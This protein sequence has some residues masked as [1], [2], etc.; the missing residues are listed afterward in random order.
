M[1]GST[2][3]HVVLST[4]MMRPREARRCGYTL[5]LRQCE[6][7][8][9]AAVGSPPEKPCLIS[10]GVGGGRT[11]RAS[12]SGRR[13]TVAQE[14]VSGACMCSGIESVVLQLAAHVTQLIIS[15]PLSLSPRPLL[16]DD[17]RGSS[18][19]SPR[20]RRV[21]LPLSRRRAESLFYPDPGC[22]GQPLALSTTNVRTASSHHHPLTLTIY[23]QL[24][25]RHRGRSLD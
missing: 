23:A 20:P 14:M 11:N 2:G 10:G 5:R 3:R 21:V 19:P 17:A 7:Y 15:P 16:H 9:P 13:S 12:R 8:R 22:Q 24:G 1:R 6:S 18:A 25:D 4:G